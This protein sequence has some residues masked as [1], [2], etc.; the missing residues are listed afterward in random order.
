VHQRHVLRAANHVKG[1]L[2]HLLVD[3]G[4]RHRHLYALGVKAGAEPDRFVVT[5]R[6][7]RGVNDSIVID[8]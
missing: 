5:Q 7:S 2:I 3:V 4:R 1:W 8:V 6:F